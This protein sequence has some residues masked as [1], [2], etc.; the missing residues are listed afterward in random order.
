[1]AGLNTPKQVQDKI[2][3]IKDQMMED[4]VLPVLH[5]ILDMVHLPLEVKIQM[6]MKLLFIIFI[7]K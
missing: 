2:T 4:F 7:Y 3:A 5:Q 1:M 6:E